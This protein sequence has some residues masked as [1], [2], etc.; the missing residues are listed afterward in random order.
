MSHPGDP[1]NNRTLAAL[2]MAQEDYIQGYAL[3]LLD[4]NIQFGT[5][6]GF[7]FVKTVREFFSSAKSFHEQYQ[8]EEDLLKDK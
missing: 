2:I 3:M 6:H 4:E 5:K 8:N 1:F 7:D